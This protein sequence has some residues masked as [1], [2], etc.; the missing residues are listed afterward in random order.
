MLT[1][2]IPLR[3]LAIGISWLGVA[4][5]ALSATLTGSILVGVPMAVAILFGPACNAALFGYQ[6]AITPDRLQ[7]RVISVIFLA[8]MSLSSL[9][10]AGWWPARALVG[11]PRRNTGLLRRHGCLRGRRHGKQGHAQYAAPIRDHGR[12]GLRQVKLPMRYEMLCGQYVAVMKH[13]RK[14]WAAAAAAALIV[15]LVP[16][17]SAVAGVARTPIP[18]PT[19]SGPIPGTV[20]GDPA[21][22]QSSR[23]PIRSSPH[24]TIWPRGLHRAGVLSVRRRRRLGPAGQPARKRCALQDPDRGAAP[25]QRPQVQ[26]HR[27][28]RVA[29]RH[30]RLRPRRAVERRGHDA[31]RLRLDRR[32]RPAGRRQPAA[33]LEP[34]PLRRHSTSPAAGV[35]NAD[36]LSYDIFAQ[37]AKAVSSRRPAL[38]AW[39]G[40]TCAPCWPSARRSRPGG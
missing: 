11:R 33:R 17:S 20:P 2:R 3:L 6:A 13:A 7:G 1:R 34:D 28:G 19:V 21:F 22:A 30:G 24:R 15:T 32:L 31:R 8:A 37:A 38:A 4:L 16:A 25:G 29:E 26:R 14:H 39:G 36:E 23:T 9:A 35:Y 40:W 12:R 27:A 5:I 10:R 18:E